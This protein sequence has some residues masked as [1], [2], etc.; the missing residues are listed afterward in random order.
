[1]Q[2]TGASVGLHNLFCTVDGVFS[3][4][5]SVLVSHDKHRPDDYVEAI[6]SIETIK[7][8]PSLIHVGEVMYPNDTQG[9]AVRVLDIGG[10]PLFGVFVGIFVIGP[11][12]LGYSQ[13]AF[14]PRSAAALTAVYPSVYDFMVDVFTYNVM[15]GVDGIAY[16][17]NDTRAISGLNTT[18]P[19]VFASISYDG[20]LVC[21]EYC[22]YL[23]IR[24]EALQWNM[25]EL[26]T[27][28]D[29]QPSYHIQLR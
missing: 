22:Y 3:N 11:Q 28:L 8:I 13:S 19:Y 2:V 29:W 25:Y 17:P 12:N 24:W 1:M 26:I 6:G 14:A 5:V 7:G 20:M 16:F 27:L 15:S 10:E 21:I 23:F 18:V 4:T 9:P